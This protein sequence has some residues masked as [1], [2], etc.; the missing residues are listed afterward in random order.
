M[1]AVT[2]MPGTGLLAKPAAL[3]FSR[4]RTRRD[5]P[6]VNLPFAAVLVV[7]EVPST[8]RQSQALRRAPHEEQWQTRMSWHPVGCVHKAFSSPSDLSRRQRKTESWQDR[9]MKAQPGR[10]PAAACSPVRGAWSSSANSIHPA[11]AP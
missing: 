10:A 11:V 9:I 5:A 6:N 3:T 7:K 2:V 8:R 4:T 1:P